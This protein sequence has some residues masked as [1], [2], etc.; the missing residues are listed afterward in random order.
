MHS[1]KKHSKDFNA[2]EFLAQKAQ[3]LKFADGILATPWE[4]VGKSLK[5]QAKKAVLD[6]YE[7]N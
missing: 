4:K 2:S 5:P 1:L 7:K 6:F 3:K